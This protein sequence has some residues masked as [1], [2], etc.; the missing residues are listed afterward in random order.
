[1][2]YINAIRGVLRLPSKIDCPSSAWLTDF[3]PSATCQS[4]RKKRR[5]LKK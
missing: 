1:M 2:T 3:L 4:R 5:D